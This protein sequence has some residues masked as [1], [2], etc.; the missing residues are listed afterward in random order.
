M[1]LRQSHVQQDNVHSTF[2]QMNLGFMHAQEVRQIE[3]IWFFLTEH[4]AQQAGVSRIYPQPEEP[5]AL[6]SFMSVLRA[7]T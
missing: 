4:L 3:A 7:A 6:F 2:R 1:P 5:G